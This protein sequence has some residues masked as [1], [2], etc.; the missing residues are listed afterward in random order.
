MEPILEEIRATF[1]CGIWFPTISSVL[2]LPDACGAVDSWGTSKHP[3]VRYA[4]WYD[5]WVLPHFT[6]Q[7]PATFDGATVYIV[8]NAMIHEH[9]GFTR[10]KHGFDRVLFMPPNKSEISMKFSLMRNIGDTS[11]TIFQVSLELFMNAV[12]MGVRN[13]LAEVRADTDAARRN[14]I[15]KLIQ[16]RPD[17]LDPYITG[18]PLVG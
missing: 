8:R 7:A 10:G 18:L 2:M 16:F 3:R 9:T 15:D 1:D 14:A 6:P 5:A 17:G 11:D 4:E 13:W 12:E